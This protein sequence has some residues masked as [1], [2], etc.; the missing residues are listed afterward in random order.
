MVFRQKVTTSGNQRQE[1]SKMPGGP[2]YERFREQALAALL[3]SA[4][5]TDA[6]RAAGVPV[7][8]MR[9]WLRRADFARE[10]AA[11]RREVLQSAVGQLH[12]LNAKAIT[13]LDQSMEC[14]HGPTQVRA[15]VAAMDLSL[16]A[17][18]QADALV[19]ERE[20]G[21]P[22]PMETGDVVIILSKRLRQLENSE[23][24]PKEKSR[25]TVALADALL[26]ALTVNVLD[27]RLAALVSVLLD[28]K[29][30]DSQ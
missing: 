25:L 6:A 2:R 17:L 4:T 26:R 9:A 8:T 15:A 22:A 29:G 30:S 21:E 16:R 28:R 5:I 20:V 10:Y 3:T 27:A 18:S 19:G 14:G 7:R 11:R 24:P 12:A 23:V 13:T 1:E